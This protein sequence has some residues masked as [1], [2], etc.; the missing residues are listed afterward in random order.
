MSRMLLALSISFF[1]ACGVSIDKVDSDAER[2]SGT[3]DTLGTPDT[4]PVD[5]DGDGLTSDEDCDDSDA[6]MPINDADCDGVL[7]ADDC[8]DCVTAKKGGEEKGDLKAKGQGARTE[9]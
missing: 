9:R 3:E 5:A 7:T 4:G 2:D 1:T 6:S 8:D